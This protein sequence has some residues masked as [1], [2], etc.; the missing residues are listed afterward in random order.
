[1]D[2]EKKDYK[3]IKVGE[4]FVENDIITQ[5]Q[6]DEAL[7][8]QKDNKERLI[9]E[10]LVT[11]GYLTKE[12]LIMALQYYFVVTDN[13]VKYADEWLDQDE[14]DMLMDRKKEKGS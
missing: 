2:K 13:T 12:E 6:M 8:L 3:S 4:F 1:M 14:I 7:V 5:E 11:L 9:G 10:I